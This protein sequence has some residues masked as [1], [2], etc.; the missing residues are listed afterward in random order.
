MGCAQRGVST[1]GWVGGQKITR[2][3]PIPAI[4]SVGPVRWLGSI[5]FVDRVNPEGTG[6]ALPG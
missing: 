6:Q 2:I 5:G 4:G 1:A 3:K